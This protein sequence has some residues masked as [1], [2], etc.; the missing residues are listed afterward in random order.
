M[1][2]F[3]SV[4]TVAT[5]SHRTKTAA[6]AVPQRENE[7][8]RGETQSVQGSA[9]CANPG[10]RGEEAGAEGGDEGGLVRIRS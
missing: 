9:T 6:V 3:F 4:D 7:G 5:S 2:Y 10:R 8:T 1:L